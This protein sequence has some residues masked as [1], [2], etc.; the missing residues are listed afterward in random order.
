MC[1]SGWEHLNM[2]RCKHAGFTLIELLTVITIIIIL[3]A[4]VLSIA[5]IAQ[6]KGARAR[7]VSEIAAMSA[8]LESYKA[9]NGAYPEDNGTGDGNYTDTLNAQVNGNPSQ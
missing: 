6:S 9:D 1:Y 7:A 8:G 3:S 4:L 5:R 2:R